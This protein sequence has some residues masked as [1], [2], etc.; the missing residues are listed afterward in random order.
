MILLNKIF[1]NFRKLF[2]MMIFENYL[3]I[4]AIFVTIKN[5]YEDKI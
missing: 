3:A 2:K 1:S 5:E 4:I